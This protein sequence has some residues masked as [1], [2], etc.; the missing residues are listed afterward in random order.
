MK[1]DYSMLCEYHKCNRK[2]WLHY[3]CDLINIHGRAALEFGSGIHVGCDVMF[4]GGTIEEAIAAFKE[5]V[6]E[7]L[8]AK[9]TVENGSE[10][11]REYYKEYVAQ[12]FDEVIATESSFMTKILDPLTGETHEYWG[13]IDKIVRWAMGI[14]VIDHKTTSMYMANFVKTIDRA[15][16][17]TGYIKI[18]QEKFKDAYGLLVDAI[19]VPKR[20]KNGTLNTQFTRIP[21]SRIDHDFDEWE[22]WVLTTIRRIQLDKKE[23]VW[24]KADI[25]E[26]CHGFNTTCP[27]SELCAMPYPI[28]QLVDYAMTTGN[29]KIQKW[30]PWKEE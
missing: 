2:F 15:H 26:I 8:D 6:P 19:H 21:S 18:V 17:F 14:T 1:I 27:Y 9:R 20:L 13:K 10:I 24:A 29:F 11:L 7:D 25:P 23:N 22:K 16:Q 30:E 12:P 4:K 3:M 5:I 28:D